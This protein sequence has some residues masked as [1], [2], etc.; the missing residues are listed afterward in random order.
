M[1]HIVSALL[2]GL[3]K[4]LEG[5]IDKLISG[6]SDAVSSLK[7]I[8]DTVGSLSAFLPSEIKLPLDI[9]KAILDAADNCNKGL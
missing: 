3:M 2:G 7:G 1:Y 8:V 4:T 9:I 6:A 5:T